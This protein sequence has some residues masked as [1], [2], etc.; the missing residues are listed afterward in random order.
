M[1]VG[2]LANGHEVLYVAV[3]SEQKVISVEILEKPPGNAKGLG[4]GARGSMQSASGAHVPSGKAIVRTYIANSSPKNAGFPATTGALNDPDNLAIDAL[5]NIYVIEDAPNSSSTGGDIWFVR[6]ED[7]DG[8]GE[9]LDHF[10]SIRVDGSEAT[11]MI[12]SPVTAT[13]FAVAVQH[14]D[15]TN[16]AS[17]PD[18]L[19]DAVWLFNVSGIDNQDF[20]E[21]LNDAGG[22]FGE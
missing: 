9:S 10:L 16:L 22:L 13:E 7:N 19:G 5:G 18:G 4:K 21:D 1:T 3:T 20:V 12:F 11:G 15:S 2:T 6:D 17:V 14:P 8:V